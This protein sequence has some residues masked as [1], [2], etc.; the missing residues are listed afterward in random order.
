MTFSTPGGNLATIIEQLLQNG[1]PN[2]DVQAF[3]NDFLLPFYRSRNDLVAKNNEGGIRDYE[4]ESSL[5]DWY[6]SRQL[7]P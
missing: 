1:H 7:L 4:Q 5:A 3:V 2:P 6:G